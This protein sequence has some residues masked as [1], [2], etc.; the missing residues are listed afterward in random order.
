MATT[1]KKK[2]IFQSVKGM[3]DILP[4]DQPLWERMRKVARDL[5]ES[6]TYNRIDTPLL[7]K[8]ELFERGIG[9]ATDIVEKQMFILKTKSDERLALRPE[10]TAAIVRAYLEQGL[11]HL[12]QPLKLYYLGPMYRYEQPQAGRLR[13]F[14][15][16]GFE[17]LG[18]ESDAVYDA[19][20]ILACYRFLEEMKLDRLNIQINSIGCKSCRL[21]YRKKLVDYYKNKNSCKTC[22]KRLAFNPLRL[23]DCR[24]KECQEMKKAAPLFLDTLCPNCSQH[25]KRVL[26]YLDE[27]RLPY[28]LNHY[29]VRGLD[30]YNRTV[31]E[32]YHECWDDA[33]ASGGRYD[34]LAEMLGGRPLSAVGGAIGWERVLLLIKN[35]N[36]TFPGRPKAKAFF[37][38]IGESAKKRSLSLIEE[39]RR[40]GII[41]QDSL[42]K[43]SLNAQLR[44]A[45]REGAAL[46]L[47]F[48]QKE[49][50]EAEIIIRD[51]KSGGQET[52]PLVKI[53][54][55]VKKRL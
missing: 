8:A 42:G 23:L 41:I 38:H 9:Q 48:G 30:Y 13:Q 54:E 21:L 15:Q 47:I 50:Y 26:E 24:E 52:V 37:I 28:L 2:P 17:I 39:L 40:G 44:A 32:I 19:Q 51:L 53:V 25:F 49:V 29:L 10:G 1:K 43:D 12:P 45:D 4:A 36:I 3:H 7:E 55:E 11:D 27:L 34:Y 35:Q 46:A 16:L 5:A 14:H 20:A 6:Y 22:K 31:F 33:L 18:G